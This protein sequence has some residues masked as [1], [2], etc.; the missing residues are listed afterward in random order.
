VVVVRSRGSAVRVVAVAA[1]LAFAA[2]ALAGTANPDPQEPNNSPRAAYGPLAAGHAYYGQFNGPEADWFWFGTPNAG[3]AVHVTV[4][5]MT[6]E[7]SSCPVEYVSLVYPDGSVATQQVARGE[8]TTFDATGTNSGD[9]FELGLSLNGCLDDFIPGYRLTVDSPEPL[10]PEAAPTS[11]CGDF[12]TA[13]DK[14]RTNVSGLKRKL[15]HASSA[16]RRTALR[17]RLQRARLD[18]AAARGRYQ[19]CVAAEQRA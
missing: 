8:T 18:L 5:N 3:Q 6:A 15:R 4:E 14:Q 1:V 7:N 17:R 13:W 10:V 16:R 2:S 19:G 11:R 9:E 12:R